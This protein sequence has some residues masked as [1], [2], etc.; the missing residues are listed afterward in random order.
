MRPMGAQLFRANRQTDMT[1]LTVP[2]ETLRMRPETIR[3]N[4][5]N[6]NSKSKADPLNAVQG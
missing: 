1:K 5:T 3:L 4:I 2:F 6:T